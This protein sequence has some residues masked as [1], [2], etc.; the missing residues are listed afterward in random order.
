[1]RFKDAV[2]YIVREE[3]DDWEIEAHPGPRN[4]LWFTFDIGKAPGAKLLDE[5][6]F[7]IDLVAR[8]NRPRHRGGTAP[9]PCRR[10]SIAPARR[11]P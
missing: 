2:Q 5:F 1:M 10:L 7:L 3:L 6:R 8:V 11:R 4:R 9:P